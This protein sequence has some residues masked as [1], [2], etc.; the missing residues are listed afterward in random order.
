[1]EPSP[2]RPAASKF[3]MA[4]L[5]ILVAGCAVAVVWTKAYYGDLTRQLELPD[6]LWKVKLHYLFRA[7]VPSLTSI[8]LALL[9]CRLRPPRP[10]IRRLARQPGAVAMA[11]VGLMLLLKSATMFAGR[12]L[13]AGLDRVWPP[14]STPGVTFAVVSDELSQ[15]FAVTE[16]GPVIAACWLLLAL[17]GRWRAE[18]T[19]VDRL[20]RCLGVCWIVVYLA[21][22]SAVYLK[23]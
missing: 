14:P 18:P 7:P 19:W 10:S 20:G 6:A 17:V 22:A 8:G 16:V 3:T 5:M 12:A 9:V 2:A 23:P 15:V 11:C 1:M 21:S 4:D 13:S